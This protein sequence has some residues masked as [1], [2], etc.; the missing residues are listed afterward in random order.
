MSAPCIIWPLCHLSAK[1]D[2][3]WWKFD[4]VLTK[5]ILH[6]FL[7]HGVFTYLITINECKWYTKQ[8]CLSVEGRQTS[9]HPRA[10]FNFV[11]IALTLAL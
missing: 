11:R 10:L 5:T 6:S 7:R 2:Q 3:N 8:D 4:E 9:D 1:N